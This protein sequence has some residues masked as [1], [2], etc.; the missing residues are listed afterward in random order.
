MRAI[1]FIVI[2]ILTLLSKTFAYPLSQLSPKKLHGE[3]IFQHENGY[4]TGLI[5]GGQFGHSA[6]KTGTFGYNADNDEWG[7]HESGANAGLEL[8]YRYLWHQFMIGPEIEFGYLGVNGKDAQPSSPG[9]D[10]IGKINSNFYT[11]FRARAG[12]YF[13]RDLIFATG[14]AIGLNATYQVMDSCNIAPC[15]GSTIDAKKNN[16]IWGYMVGI[17]VEHWINSQWSVKL[18][19]FYFDLLSQDFNGT[20]SLGNNYDWTGKTSGCIIRTGFNYHL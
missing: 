4:Y 6:D 19:S 11:A 17:G 8:G 12:F 15:G 13:D 2:F 7:Y 9:L 14:G 5:V 1:F 20:T 18:E 3:K 10:T 16:F